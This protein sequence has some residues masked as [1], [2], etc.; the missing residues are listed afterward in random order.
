M[1]KDKVVSE[2]IAFGVESTSVNFSD[3]MACR[4]FRKFEG[5]MQLHNCLVADWWLVFDL[6]N[7][8]VFAFLD[9]F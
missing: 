9:H 1:I 3:A 4:F 6:F 5:S 2:V 7:W 8:H